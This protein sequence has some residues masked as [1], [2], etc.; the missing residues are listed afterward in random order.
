MKIVT[1]D[2]MIQLEENAKV[3]GISYKTM[4]ENAGAGIADWV[5]AHLALK[6]GVIGLVGSGNN[7]GDTL[8]ALAELSK[9]NVRTVAF[10]AKRRDDD[11]LLTEYVEAGGAVVDISAT[12]DL[13]LLEATLVPGSVVLDG[14]LGTGFTLPLRGPLA[15]LM[16]AIQMLVKNRSQVRIIAIDCPS[17]VNCDTGEVSP[18]TLKAEYTLTMAAVK[19][20]LL[21]FPAHAYAGEIHGIEIGIPIDEAV[22]GHALPMMVDGK[23]RTD[24]LPDRPETGHKG[25]FGT[26][27]VIAGSIPFTGAAFLAGKAA[28]RAGCGLV[29][30]ATLA[31]VQ[32][33]LS[34]RLIETIWTPLPELK[35]G[36]DPEGVEALAPALAKADSLVIG[37][38]W[39]LNDANLAFLDKLLKIL[40]KDLPTLVDADGLKLL[41]QLGDWWSRVP[42]QVVLT[43]HPGEMAILTG[44]EIAQIEADRWE[45][46]KGYAQKWGVVLLLKGPLTVIAAPGGTVY[47]NPVSD[48]ALATA[49]SGDVLSGVLGGLMAQGA[50]AEEAAALGASLHGA[51]GLAARNRLG[52]SA[53]VT[54]LDILDQLGKGD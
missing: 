50:S 12:K 3:G 43:P 11:P 41:R 15:A 35:G 2:E 38:G 47:I 18:N 26:C 22:L 36:Y 30:V 39:G 28:Y 27:L 10:L 42:R 13:S 21:K 6:R 29:N 40:P 8:I 34:G 49:G 9:R 14:I 19:Q 5:Y 53:S 23:Y 37:P 45:I 7:G 44:L 20:G 31:P 32:Q 52:T 17:G 25:T 4:M 33:A 1:V 51:A 46:A 24:H 48:S 54:A 16:A